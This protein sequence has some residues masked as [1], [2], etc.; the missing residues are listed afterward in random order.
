MFGTKEDEQ[1]IPVQRWKRSTSG[2]AQPCKAKVKLPLPSL[3]ALIT[4]QEHCLPDGLRGQ[5]QLAQTLL[6]LQSQLLA[7]HKF[8]W[9]LHLCAQLSSVFATT[10]QTNTQPDLM[11]NE[12]VHLVG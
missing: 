12:F 10:E 2:T 3:Q 4:Q 1:H 7:Q 5:A 6:F 9:A 11:A 8:D